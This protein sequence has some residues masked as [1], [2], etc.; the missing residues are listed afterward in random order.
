MRHSE[1]RGCNQGWLEPPWGDESCLE[2]PPLFLTWLKS[3]SKT[4]R[5]RDGLAG[6]SLS[7]QAMRSSH[8]GWCKNDPDGLAPL[9][10]TQQSDHGLPSAAT[11]LNGTSAKPGVLQVVAWGISRAKSC[12]W[13]DGLY[14][15]SL[16][17]ARK[18]TEAGARR[19]WCLHV[20]IFPRT[21]TVFPWNQNKTNYFWNCL[22]EGVFNPKT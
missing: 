5:R 21:S 15:S 18:G 2:V 4:Q 7:F 19:G 9:D 11:L 1:E 20:P 16:S 12:S 22:D 6:C 3:F 17:S 14:P 8:T 13:G 10:W